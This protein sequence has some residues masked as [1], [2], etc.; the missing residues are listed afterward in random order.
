MK[1]VVIAV[2]ILLALVTPAFAQ[3]LPPTAVEAVKQAH[4]ILAALAMVAGG[5]FGSVLMDAL[6]KLPFLSQERREQAGQWLAA[7]ITAGLSGLLGYALEY[8]MTYAVDLDG[9]GLWAAIGT[10]IAVFGAP[11]AAEFRHRWR[12]RNE[13][14]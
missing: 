12:K 9:T 6:K 14:R 13:V 5:F 8:G 1:K 2:M 7:V 11:V 10:L 3:D 4:L